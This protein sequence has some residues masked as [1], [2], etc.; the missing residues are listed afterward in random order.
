MTWVFRAVALIGAPLLVY[1]NISKDAK[2]LGIGLAAGVLIVGIEALIERVKLLTIIVGL[3]GAFMGLLLAKFV[4][5]GI[6]QMDNQNILK[7]WEQYYLLIQVAFAY[8]GMMVMIQKFPE[9]GDLDKDILAAGKRRGSELKVLDTS[10]IIDG[11]IMDVCQTRFL[12]GTLIVPRFVLNELHALADSPDSM[13]R[14]RG[15]RGLDILARMQEEKLVPMKILDKEIP[16]LSDVD[17]K[18]VRLARDLGAQLVTTDFN[19]N[20][21]GALESIVVLNINDLTAALK[22]V[23]LPGE[24]MSVFVMREGKERDQGVGYLDD[25][26]MVVIEDGK[27]LIGKRADVAVV[28]ILQTS[29]G[30]MIF[31]KARGGQQSQPQPAAPA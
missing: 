22:P 12:S 15:R 26:T 1:F 6:A 29:A 11:R 28:S 17:S 19:M 8:L 2:G 3:L 21:M 18:V 14:A 7:F 16:E 13:K 31:A 20:K 9:F 30:R 5:Y 4:D 25:G 24:V 27:R 10:A 23:V